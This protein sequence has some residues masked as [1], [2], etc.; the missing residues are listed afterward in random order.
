MTLDCWSAHMATMVDLEPTVRQ[1]LPQ[2]RPVADCWQPSD[3]LPDLTAEG[4]QD[5][6]QALRRDAAGLSD[7]VL[8]VLVGNIV[9]EEALPS[10]Q[11]ALNRFAGMTDATGTEPHAWAQWS[12][13]WTAEEK[14]HGDV[15]RA[16]LMLSGR[17]C[18]RTVEVTV[19]H[20][21]R[22]GFDTCAEGDPYRGLAY[23]SF[24]EH[25]TKTSWNQLGKICGEQGAPLLHRICG[26]VAADEARHERVYAALLR[27][28]VLRDPDGALEALDAT[29]CRSIVMPARTMHDG[30]DGRL[31]TH[32]ADVGQRIGVYGLRDYAANMDQLIATLGVTSLVGLSG[33]AERA[34]E[35][36]CALPARFRALA[37]ERE[38]RPARPVAFRWIH[39]RSA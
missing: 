10:Y 15:T 16:Y 18:L 19:Q 26:V 27:E 25:A 39:D 9:T 28:V 2:L 17:V 32:F 1:L 14:R 6:V 7:E 24:Q 29:L 35:A 8:V 34:R 5:G 33:E 22:N 12:R 37:E 13:G 23:A 20:L 31:F 3:F 36:I 21:L 30:H 38:A 4:W 11:T